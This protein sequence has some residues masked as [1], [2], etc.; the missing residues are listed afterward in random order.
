LT[1]SYSDLPSWA[2]WLVVL[3]II[4]GAIVGIIALARKV[5]PLIAR[6]VHTLDDLD[7]LPQFMVTTAATLAAQDQQLQDIHHQTHENGG[8]SLKDGLKRVEKGVA[9]LYARVD[10]T[11]KDLIQL[12]TDLEN[13]KP[14]VRKRKPPTPKGETP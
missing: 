10:A 14:V 13:T 12:R 5:W 6:I 7:S 2:Q 8:G 1:I 3:A 11:D 9:G 4:I